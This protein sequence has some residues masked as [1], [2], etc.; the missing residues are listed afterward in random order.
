MLDTN[1]FNRLLDGLWDISHLPDDAP[2]YVTHV[3]HD[4]L[5][6]TPNPRRRDDL[7][8][9]FNTVAPI[10]ISTESMIVGISRVGE[11][12]ISDGVEYEEFLQELTKHKK[13]SNNP[14]DALIAETALK[15]GFTLVSTDSTLITVMAARGGKTL[16][17]K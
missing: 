4:E 16:E 3:Q 8:G 17:I 2:C 10:S 12:R 1:V 9:K 13:Q 15:S 5:A 14:Q 7:L 6:R 11:C